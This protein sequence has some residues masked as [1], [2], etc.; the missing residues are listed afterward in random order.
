MIVA[1]EPLEYG[2]V[3]ERRDRDKEREEVQCNMFMKTTQLS[4]IIISMRLEYMVR[5]REACAKEIRWD[6][7]SLIKDERR[8]TKRN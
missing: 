3:P 7:P 4:T 1:V 2:P 6:L 5:L 8:R